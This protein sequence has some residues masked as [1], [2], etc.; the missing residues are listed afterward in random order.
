MAARTSGQGGGRGEAVRNHTTAP[1]QAILP[2]TLPK[3]NSRQAVILQ[4]LRSGE[5]RTG[6]P[7][8][9]GWY[10]VEGRA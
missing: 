4:A 10:W 6:Y 2:P 5:H 8:K 7:S 1:A 3:P 9:G